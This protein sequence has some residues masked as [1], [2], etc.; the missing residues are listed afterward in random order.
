MSPFLQVPAL[1]ILAGLLVRWAPNRQEFE[2]LQGYC[3][4][5]YILSQSELTFEVFEPLF[6]IATH[7]EERSQRRGALKDRGCT[8]LIT[9]LLPLC[10]PPLQRTILRAIEDSFLSSPQIACRLWMDTPGL[11]LPIIL[12]FLRTM[13][14]SL[15]TTLLAILGQMAPFWGPTE[16]EQLFTF[17]IGDQQAAVEGKAQILELLNQVRACVRMRPCVRVHV[18]ARACHPL[19]VQ[20]C[21]KFSADGTLEGGRGS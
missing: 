14:S 2:D 8:L 9:D 10:A 11:G 19:C 4:L 18:C 15:Y 20:S 1:R 12:N 5:L 3:V 6:E 16:V 17:V 7:G 21:S 13:A